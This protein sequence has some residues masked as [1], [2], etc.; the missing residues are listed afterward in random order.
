MFEIKRAKRLSQALV[1]FV[2]ARA[3]LFT[4]HRMTGLPMRATNRHFKTI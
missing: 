4:H 2:A 1:H 3:S